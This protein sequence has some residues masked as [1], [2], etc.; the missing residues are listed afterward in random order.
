M[1]SGN[2]VAARTLLEAGADVDDDEISDGWTALQKAIDIQNLPLVKLLLEHDADATAKGH[3]HRDAITMA[4]ARK[5][6]DIVRAVLRC[7]GE[8]GQQRQH[9]RRCRRRRTHAAS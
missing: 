5:S 1:L 4:A 9:A 3:R 6:P 8:T 7:P 2:L